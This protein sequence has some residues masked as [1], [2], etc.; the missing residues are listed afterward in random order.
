MESYIAKTLA[1]LERKLRALEASHQAKIQTL[2]ASFQAGRLTLVTTIKNL[3]QLGRGTTKPPVPDAA[4]PGAQK[5]RRK[6]RKWSRAK[7]PPGSRAKS[8]AELILEAVL[9]QLRRQ[10]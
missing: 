10:T 7:S 4:A 2:E 8:P 9:A 3:Q 1:D 5:V 6:R